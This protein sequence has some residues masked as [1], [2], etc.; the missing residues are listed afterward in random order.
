MRFW[1]GQR[2][3]IFK[4]INYA[5]RIPE[6]HQIVIFCIVEYKQGQLG[7]NP[8]L[9]SPKSKI[10]TKSKCILVNPKAEEIDNGETQTLV[11]NV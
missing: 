6:W 7:P 10:Q 11:A 9:P 2:G 1:D 5:P 3:D 4:P 8:F